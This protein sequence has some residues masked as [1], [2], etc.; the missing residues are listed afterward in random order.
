MSTLILRSVDHARKR[1][2]EYA[3]SIQPGLFGDWCL[4]T[5]WGR[6]GAAT[7]QQRR[8]WYATAEEAEAQQRRI[9]KRRKRH[10]YQLTGQQA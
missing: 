6:I 1:Y 2:R 10:G 9:L 4:Q 8:Y 5:H 7:G 3:M